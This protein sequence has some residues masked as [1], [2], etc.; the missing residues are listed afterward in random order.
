[1]TD[2]SRFAAYR[3][4]LRG[5]P[6]RVLQPHGTVA[7]ARRH[8]RAREPLCAACAVEWRR[9]QAEMYQRRKG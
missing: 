7:A 4:R 3:D 2:R 5:G 6:P 1:M 8:Q 9:H